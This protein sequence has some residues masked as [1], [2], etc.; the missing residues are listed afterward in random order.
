LPIQE[1]PHFVLGTASLSILSHDPD[2]PTVSIISLWNAFSPDMLEL[3]PPLPVGD[4]RTM[5]EKALQRW[6]TDGGEIPPD[7]VEA[8]PL[9]R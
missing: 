1:G 4:T 6:E 9:S 3:Q 5:K 2:H 8:R 7:P